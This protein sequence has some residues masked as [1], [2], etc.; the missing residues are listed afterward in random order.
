MSTYRAAVVREFGPPENVHIEDFPV[1]TELP[2]DA[3]VVAV[4][5]AGVNPVD[6]RIRSGSFG[7]S[8][9][10]V[11]GSEFAG[12]VIAAGSD[13][14]ASTVGSEVVGF[15]TPGS[16]SDLVVTSA[17]AL[18]AR[19]AQ[20]PSDVAGGLSGVGQ[21][22]MTVI[23]RLS[24]TADDVVV[25]HG[26]SGGVGTVLVQLLVARGATVIGTAGAS[27]Q[28]HLRG[29]GALAVQ[30]GVGLAERVAA[31]TPSPVTMSVDLAGTAEAGDLARSVLAA[32]GQAITLVPETAQSHGIELV[33][34]SRSRARLEALLDAVAT[35]DLELPVVS[36]PFTDIVEAHR[37]VDAK[38]SRGKLVLD[39]ADNQH[40]P[41]GAA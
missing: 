10:Y 20:V 3:I 4:R 22:A 35:G 1:P 39:F 26:A 32:D 24:P 19:P 41:T 37:R 30:Y 14:S 8:V 29:L 21:T 5:S 2:A 13:V 17:A 9:P 12:T 33:R 16:H 34:T 15:G 36:V 6:G 18:V 7:G 28:D 40:L 38:H 11:V 23:D 31:A 25:V 27:N